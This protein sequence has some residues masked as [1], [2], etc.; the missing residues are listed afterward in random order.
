MA[1][2]FVVDSNPGDIDKL[3]LYDQTM[4]NIYK[5]I[6]FRSEDHKC[7]VLFNKEQ[8]TGFALTNLTIDVDNSKCFYI[9]L[10]YIKPES[11]DGKLVKRCLEMLKDEAK[12]QGCK[13]VIFPTSR[14][15]KIFKRFLGKT[16]TPYCTLLKEKI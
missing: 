14:D 5:A 7:W 13:Y 16:V 15:P 9:Y 1:M 6:S 2:E 12:K 10:A 8:A 3:G 4:L 11:R